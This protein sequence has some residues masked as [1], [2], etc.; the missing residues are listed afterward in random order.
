VLQEAQTA[1]RK[2]VIL[3]IRC[4]HLCLYLR[5]GGHWA[6]ISHPAMRLNIDRPNAHPSMSDAY[7]RELIL[8]DCSIWEIVVT[9]VPVCYSDSQVLHTKSGILCHEQNW[10]DSICGE[11]NKAKKW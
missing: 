4:L 1:L 2:C 6:I 11:T 5:G 3:Y 10:D 8:Y 7:S 9:V